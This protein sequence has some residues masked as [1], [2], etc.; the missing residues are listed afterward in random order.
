M[1]NLSKSNKSQMSLKCLENSQNKLYSQT[2][3]YGENL[4][5]NMETFLFQKNSF[6]RDLPLNDA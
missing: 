6:L 1:P 4:F 2:G 5:V 3:F